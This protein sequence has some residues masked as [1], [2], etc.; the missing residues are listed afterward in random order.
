MSGLPCGEKWTQRKTI[1]A[2]V[3][4]WIAEVNAVE[5]AAQK[6]IRDAKS[7]KHLYEPIARY[8]LS[9]KSVEMLG[10]LSEREAE[11]NQFHKVA[12]PAPPPRIGSTFVRILKPSYSRPNY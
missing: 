11:G 7:R 8:L 10:K 9:R 2:E 12:D 1:S 4:S 3:E 5:E 6:F